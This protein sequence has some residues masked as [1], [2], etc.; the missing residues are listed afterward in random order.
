M[1]PLQTGRQGDGETRRRY[2]ETVAGIL[3]H[4][5]L[6]GLCGNSEIP[7]TEVGRLL[8]SGLLVGGIRHFSDD[9]DSGWISR[10]RSLL[11]MV[12]ASTTARFDRAY[13]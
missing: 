10:W 13:K 5:R 9:L 1:K 8:K 3:I 11:F 2:A 7:P 12:Q 6:Q 4:T